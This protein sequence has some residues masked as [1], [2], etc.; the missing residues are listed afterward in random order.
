MVEYLTELFQYVCDMG[1]VSVKGT[2]LVVMSKMEEGLVRWQDLKKVNKIRKTYVRLSLASNSSHTQE[3]SGSN[4]KKGNRKQ[5]TIPCKDFNE[6]SVK[7][8][9]TMR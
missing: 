3:H 2:H 8:V 4:P 9:M 1:W 5:S 6:G 7:R